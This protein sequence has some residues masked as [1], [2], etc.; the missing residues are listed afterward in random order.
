MGKVLVWHSVAYSQKI[1]GARSSSLSH[2]FLILQTTNYFFSM[3]D[4]L[5]LFMMF[6]GGSVQERCYKNYFSKTATSSSQGEK[7]V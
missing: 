1:H 4:D 6:S 3:N 5:F 7:E 2:F